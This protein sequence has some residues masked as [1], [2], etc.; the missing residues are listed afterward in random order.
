MQAGGALPGFRKD[1]AGGT[2]RIL[3][4]SM[5][6]GGVF[7]PRP[8]EA[9]SSPDPSLGPVGPTSTDPD[10]TPTVTTESPQAR[11]LREKLERQWATSSPSTGK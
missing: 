3:P 7:T 5:V 2:R 6:G 4:T 10:A 11:Q 9:I 1:D 8:G